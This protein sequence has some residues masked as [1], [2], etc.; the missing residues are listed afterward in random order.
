[1]NKHPETIFSPE[2]VEKV[3]SI[4]NVL[5]EFLDNQIF[6]IQDELKKKYPHSSEKTLS[7]ILNQFATLDGTKR[8][9]TE[10]ELTLPGS[11]NGLLKE[12]LLQLENAR[13]LRRDEDAYELAHDTLAKRIAE[14][15]SAEEIAILESVQI[16][17]S[18]FQTFHKTRSILTP[19]ELEIIDKYD[20]ELTSKNLISKD[21]WR[22]VKVSKRRNRN[23]NV[24]V[25]SLIAGV[26]LILAIFGIY[27]QWN[28]KIASKEAKA[29]EFAALALKTFQQS[30]RTQALRIA[31]ASHNFYPQSKSA[32]QTL[33]DIVSEST[34]PFYKYIFD[35]HDDAVT[36]IAFSPNNDL[37]LTGSYDSTAWLLEPNGNALHRLKGHRDGISAVAFS[38]DGTT[39]V[40]G[41]WDNTL[42]LWNTNGDELQELKGHYLDIS[43]VAFSPDGNTI[44]SGS[45][46]KTAKLWNKQGKVLQTYS[47]HD[48]FISAV[49]FSP[50]N[51]TVLTASWDKTIKLWTIDGKLLRTY[52][53]HRFG[54]TS[55]D[56]SP[57]GQNILTGSWDKTIRLW[58]ID[59]QLIR[60][61]IGHEK[62]V[63]TVRFSKDGKRIFSAG[64]DN[65]VIQWDVNGQMLQT[66][67]GHK[68]EVFD[69]AV[70]K[71]GRFMASGGRDNLV[72]L[73]NIKGLEKRSFGDNNG[74]IVT[75]DF[76]PDGSKML[77]AGHDHKAII[78][79]TL[80]KMLFK[81]EGHTAKIQVARYSPDGKYIITAGEDRTAKLWNESGK[82]LKTFGGHDYGIKSAAF[83]ANDKYLITGDDSGKIILR[84]LPSGKEIF[85]KGF[86]ARTVYDATFSPEGDHILLGFWDKTVRVLNLKGDSIQQL[87]VGA[88]VL[89]VDYAREGKILTG[90]G[91]GK[92]ILWSSDGR[93]I[94]EYN[95]HRK[96][97]YSVAFSP[98]EKYF[99]SASFDNTA[100]LWD[101]EDNQI[102][103]VSYKGHSAAVNEITFS[104]DGKSITTVSGDGTC[105]IWNTRESFLKNEIA[106]LS[107]AQKIKFGILPEK[108]S[109]LITPQKVYTS[110]RS[111]RWI[112]VPEERIWTDERKTQAPN[113]AESKIW[114]SLH[115]SRKAYKESD[116]KGKLELQQKAIDLIEDA[117]KEDQDITI[118]MRWTPDAIAFAYAQLGYMLQLNNKPKEAIKVCNRGLNIKRVPDLKSWNQTEEW[119][120][121]RKAISHVILGYENL[122]YK[123]L[124]TLYSD[125]LIHRETLFGQAFPSV[126]G[127]RPS[128]NLTYKDVVKKDI[129]NLEQAEIPMDNFKQIKYQLNK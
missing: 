16:I 32:R 114:A 10:E 36:S 123:T 93:K 42:K 41:S 95:G 46:D 66:Y 94:R 13:I 82:L 35:G 39:L 33:H 50:D 102:P 23:R 75:L 80:G 30:D 47:G 9:L 96:A 59:G 125:S 105:K 61:F 55:I 40:T 57:D 120:N 118:K 8:P 117:V 91:I 92:V 25:F 67:I 107:I 115:Y 128:K 110:Q 1:M 29:S 14:Q 73:W 2:L 86:N 38:P 72:F 45:W 84:E 111:G 83:S 101:I 79:D 85:S 56:I 51:K 69:L 113:S 43:A 103:M 71:N 37:I 70:S 104:P 11:Q 53:G 116:L 26:I 99:A 49:A 78:W 112:R 87:K 81:L 62:G 3:G 74:S 106:E 98:D 65:N 77:T 18:R 34:P 31:E 97:V 54:V 109:V 64:Q 76:S 52:S 22:F 28:K 4:S 6:N 108:D 48:H 19:S 12:C 17:K 127:I 88:R 63:E 5:S 119:I 15:R 7:S 89:C 129:E 21:E 27:A 68:Q 126:A 20:E 58:D 60:T 121:Y 24:F 100:I 44:L 90:D 122:A 124:D